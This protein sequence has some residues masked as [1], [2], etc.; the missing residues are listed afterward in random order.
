[1]FFTLS[2]FILLVHMLVGVLAVVVALF[3]V[4]LYLPIYSPTPLQPIEWCL[5][6]GWLILGIILFIINKA[7]ENGK[8][9]EKEI[10]YQM[11]GDEYKRF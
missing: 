11:F 1:M 7:G 4:S 3:M 10:E 2:T 8:V 5:V 9:E 6:G